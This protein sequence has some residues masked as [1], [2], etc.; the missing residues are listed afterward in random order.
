[1]HGAR[2][3]DCPAGGIVHVGDM[4]GGLGDVELEL[5]VRERLVEGCLGDGD[6]QAQLVQRPLDLDF[7][8]KVDVAELMVVAVEGLRRHLA[9]R[10][11][12]VLLEWQQIH[13][14][15]LNDTQGM[16]DLAL[17]PGEELAGYSPAPR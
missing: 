2:V 8:W 16:G 15:D 9:V 3:F 14:A 12:D 10:V 17:G 5:V 13:A 1:M 7:G 4:G 6:G 11:V